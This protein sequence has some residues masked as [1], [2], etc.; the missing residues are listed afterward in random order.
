MS[1][2]KLM[3][4][5]FRTIFVCVCVWLLM[6]RT[7]YGTMML[8]H[9]KLSVAVIFGTCAHGTLG[10][11]P[12]VR[13]PGPT[14]VRQNSNLRDT[15]SFQTKKFS[16]VKFIIYLLEHRTVKYIYKQ[17]IVTK[18]NNILVYQMC[19]LYKIRQ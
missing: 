3:M 16:K 15:D 14:S 9:I 19:W 4:E 11:H 17:S 12:K 8:F 2:S 5:I 18:Q 10:L 7:V 1:Q 6:S 13:N